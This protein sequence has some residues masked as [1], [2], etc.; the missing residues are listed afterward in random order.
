MSLLNYNQQKGPHVA[1]GMK[2]LRWSSS[3][4]SL[5]AGL[6]AVAV[7]NGMTQLSVL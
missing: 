4:L 3:T 6:Q 2:A 5:S 1:D 7:G